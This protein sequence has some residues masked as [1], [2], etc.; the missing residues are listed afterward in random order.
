MEGAMHND[1]LVKRIQR[2]WQH[3]MEDL[4]NS[5]CVLLCYKHF[6]LLLLIERY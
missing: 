2:N 1:W 5:A 6:Y 3:R 4:P